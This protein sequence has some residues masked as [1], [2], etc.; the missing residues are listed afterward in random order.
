[1]LEIV[2]SPLE[3]LP[4]LSSGWQ[5]GEKDGGSKRRGGSRKKDLACKMTKDSL[6]KIFFK[7]LGMGFDVVLGSLTFQN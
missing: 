4:S 1:M 2:D 5:M 3:T 7:L 6:Q